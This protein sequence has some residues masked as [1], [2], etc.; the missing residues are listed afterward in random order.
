MLPTKSRA[1]EPIGPE[2]TTAHMPWENYESATSG[3]NQRP[4]IRDQP[5][6][7]E[8]TAW[9]TNQR[10]DFVNQR[11]FRESGK[12]VAVIP[13]QRRGISINRAERL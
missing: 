10:P 9:V 12:Q 6:F 8:S 4:R 5:L 2:L 3:S 7:S 11:R 1:G 13:N